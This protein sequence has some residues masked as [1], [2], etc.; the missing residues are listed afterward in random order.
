M[1]NEIDEFVG[2]CFTCEHLSLAGEAEHFEC[3]HEK[4]K[5]LFE[6]RTSDTCNLY[7]DMQVL[8]INNK[9]KRK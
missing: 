8:L 9:K 2:H 6:I 7:V 5:G 3:Q 4:N 1:F